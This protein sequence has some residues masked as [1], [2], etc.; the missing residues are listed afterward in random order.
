[1]KPNDIDDM[2]KFLID[3]LKNINLDE[4]S[5][6]YIKNITLKAKYRKIKEKQKIT[7]AYKMVASFIFLVVFILGAY[8]YV[9]NNR[10]NYNV[11]IKSNE[12]SEELNNDKKEKCIVYSKIDADSTS[13]RVVLDVEEMYNLSDVIAIVR[14]D[15]IN[16]TNYDKKY[17]YQFDGEDGY[18]FV[19]TIGKLSIIDS[20]KGNFKAGDVIEFRKK[21]GRI[22]YTQYLKYHE[23][24]PNASR[25]MDMENECQESINKGIDIDDIYVD[26]S[27]GYKNINIESGKTYLVYLTEKKS[28][29]WIQSS[30]NAIMEYNSENNTVL[31]NIT[32]EWELLNKYVKD[33][34]ENEI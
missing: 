25:D 32:G 34:I 26:I 19:R 16:V 29:Y 1:M 21:G 24:Y 23:E 30:E 6:D 11:N 14:I 15:E 13:S 2:D 5:S 28:G 7:I 31:N 9:L 12:N 4:C 18:T 10:S 20:I 27:I 22:K 3:G 33:N 17:E 8:I